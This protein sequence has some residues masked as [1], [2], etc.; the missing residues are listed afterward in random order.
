[1]LKA[2]ESCLIE[3]LLGY[4]KRGNELGF[5]KLVL[6]MRKEEALSQWLIEQLIS[7]T[8]FLGVSC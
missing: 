1:M 8:L 4:K 7:T 3:G 5:D 6:G 2:D